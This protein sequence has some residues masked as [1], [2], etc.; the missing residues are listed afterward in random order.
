[1]KPHVGPLQVRP[2]GERALSARVLL[3]LS[4]QFN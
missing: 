1:M 2:L 4:R 3:G